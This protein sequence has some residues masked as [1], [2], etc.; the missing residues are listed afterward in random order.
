MSRFRESSAH[1]GEDCTQ[2]NL[3]QDECRD[4]TK[5]FKACAHWG[6]YISAA[7]AAGIP[8]VRPKTVA[9]VV[10]D[11]CG[12]VHLSSGA[13]DNLCYFDTPTPPAAHSQ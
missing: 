2:P 13:A 9:A 8:S 10:T 4:N 6:D 11:N 12:R 7:A 1:E 5:L 3:Q